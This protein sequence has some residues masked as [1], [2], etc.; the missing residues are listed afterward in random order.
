MPPFRHADT[1]AGKL[2]DVGWHQ[3]SPVNF[4][5]T[6]TINSLPRAHHHAIHTSRCHLPL[7]WIL[8][9]QLLLAPATVML[10]LAATIPVLLDLLSLSESRV[11]TT[12]YRNICQNCILCD[13]LSRR[14]LSPT[15]G[16]LGPDHPRTHR[17]GGFDT[18][19]DLVTV[20]GQLANAGPRDWGCRLVTFCG[21]TL[22]CLFTLD[23]FAF[24]GLSFLCHGITSE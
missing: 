24:R 16:T 5:G 13:T 22:E 7:S 17:L 11:S 23:Y 3:T 8:C 6:N 1:P 21:R 14:C 20:W 10:W 19:P 2:G 15:P 18:R 12:L 9:R 4:V